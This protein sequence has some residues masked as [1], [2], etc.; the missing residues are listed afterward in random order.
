MAELLALVLLA[1]AVAVT[2][3]LQRRRPPGRPFDAERIGLL[4]MTTTLVIFG[5]HSFVDWT[6]FV[7]GVTVP[8]LVAGGWLAARGGG[9]WRRSRGSRSATA[10]ARGGVPSWPPGRSS[11]RW[12]RPGR[13]G[14]RSGRSRRPTR[15]STSSPP[16]RRRSAPPASSPPPRTGATRS[17]SIRCS[18]RPRSSARRATA[19]APSAPSSRPCGSSRPTP[20]PGTRWPSSSSTSSSSPPPRARR[21]ARRCTSI[22]GRRGH[23][24]LLEVNRTATATS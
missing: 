4:T 22:Q 24:L 15:R 10:S 5:V 13:P 11:W 6:W 14:S 1:L 12:S 8:V 19:P 7:P 2:L 23:Q 21:S 20:R 9:R 18:P 3:G 17:R 16:T